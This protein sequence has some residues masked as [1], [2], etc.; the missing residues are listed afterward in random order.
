MGRHRLFE[1]E[2]SKI[3]ERLLKIKLPKI[4]NK[5][6]T[7]IHERALKLATKKINYPTCK[8][9][10]SEIELEELSESQRIKPLDYEVN[11]GNTN[12]SVSSCGHIFH[13][14]CIEHILDKDHCPF[15][16]SENNFSRLFI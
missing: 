1:I 10:F 8:I 13:T 16:R 6:R 2:K 14:Q 9:C 4:T 12:V 5:K 7:I 11:T 15:C 3:N